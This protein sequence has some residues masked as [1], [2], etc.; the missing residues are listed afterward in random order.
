MTDTTK[1]SARTSHGAVKIA[2]MTGTADERAFYDLNA[3]WITAHFEMEPSDVQILNHPHREVIEPGGQVYLAHREGRPVGC[4]ALMAYGP[5]VYKVAK[6]AVS[7][8][9]RGQGTGRQLMVHAMEQARRL[10]A[11]TLYLASSS[12][13]VPAIALYTS[14]GFQRLSAEKWPFARFARADVFMCLT[15]GSQEAGVSDAT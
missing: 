1:A 14:L 12:R 3:E 6:M 7:P 5:G 8:D 15:L 4:V 10:G 2:P 11:Q 9:H 13:L